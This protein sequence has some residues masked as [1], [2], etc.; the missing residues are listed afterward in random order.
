MPMHEMPVVGAVYENE[1]GQTFEVLSF[2]ENEGILEIEYE[3]GAVEEIDVD[4]WYALDVELVSDDDD[5]DEEDDED[6]DYDD[7]DDDFDD[8]EDGDYDDDDDEDR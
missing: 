5:E 1:D 2:D 8:D 7:D 4:A 3:N 6:E